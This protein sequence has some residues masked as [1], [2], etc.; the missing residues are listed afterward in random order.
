MPGAPGEDPGGGGRAAVTGAAGRRNGDV[1]DQDQGR[2]QATR[3]LPSTPSCGPAFPSPSVK[4]P[5]SVRAN[6]HGAPILSARLP[7]AAEKLGEIGGPLADYALHF[8]HAE[9]L[10][11]PV[12]Q[13]RT[14]EQREERSSQ[15]V[16][17]VSSQSK[18]WVI[19]PGR[20]RPARASPFLFVPRPRA[21]CERAAMEPDQ[22]R[23]GTI[24]LNSSRGESG[25]MIT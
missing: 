13:R 20:E 9:C 7:K 5:Q 2:K 10:R 3:S 14:C 25:P 18:C 6:L 15:K 24:H 21:R 4:P 17:L 12:R 22:F 1:R 11:N 16:W 23:S 8:W 19:V